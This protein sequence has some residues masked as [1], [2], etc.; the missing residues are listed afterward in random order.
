MHGTTSRRLIWVPI[1]H[2][3]EDLGSLKDSVRRLHVRRSGRGGWQRGQKLIEAMWTNIDRE[4]A[5]LELDDGRVRL[6]QDGLACCG[7]EEEIVRDLAKI[8]S[9]N[10]QLLLKLMARGA[11][12]MGTESPAL[13]L[14]EYEISRHAVLAAGSAAGASPEQREASDRI[15]KQR[16]EF[17]ARRINETLLPG[18]TG[19]AFL[20]LLHSLAGLLAPDMEVLKLETAP[21]TVARNAGRG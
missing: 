3:P 16:D 20:G 6:Y 1:I 17:V 4:I 5:R 18:E 8:G 10:H 9:R 12:I 21:A 15:L 19:L 2:T 7:K 13:L 14:E 11:C